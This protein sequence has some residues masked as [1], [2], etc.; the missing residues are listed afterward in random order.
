MENMDAIDVKD[1]IEFEDSRR[2]RELPSG[3]S[4]FPSASA[5]EAMSTI[6]SRRAGS[7]ALQILRNIA[8]DD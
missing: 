3:G 6:C 7:R 2:C 1:P 8:A 4:E 5:L